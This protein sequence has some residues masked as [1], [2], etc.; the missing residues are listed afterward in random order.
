MLRS[1]ATAR[2]SAGWALLVA[3]FLLILLGG[4]FRLRSQERPLTV[5]ATPAVT[6]AGASP[7]PIL[8]A[9]AVV[10]I[11]PAG[12]TYEVQPGDTLSSIAARYDVTVEDMV[13]ANDIVD[14]NLIKAGQ[15][16]VIP[17]PQGR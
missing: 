9:T 10:T 7:T 6:K 3:L 1:D 17:K 11:V 16:L 12:T 4:C 5:T 8:A 13:K 15:K 2:S 14:P